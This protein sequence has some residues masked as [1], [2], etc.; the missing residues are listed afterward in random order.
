[1]LKPVNYRLVDA[2]LDLAYN[3]IEHGWDLELGLKDLKARQKSPYTPSVTLPELQAAGVALAFAT[4]FVD[5][6]KYPTPEL[7]HRAAKAQLDRYRRWQDEG[8]VRIVQSRAELQSHLSTWEKDRV[9]GLV[10]LMEGAEPVRRPEEVAHWAKEGVRILGPAWQDT[11]YAGGTGGQKGLTEAGRELLKAMEETGL[12]L[13]L[14]HLS[15]A[16]YFDA[17]EAFSGP[18]LVSHANYRPLAGGPENRHLSEKQLHA[19]KGRGAVVGVVLYNRF[20]DPDWERT[21]P[22]PPLA[23]V[24]RHAEAVARVLGWEAVGIGSDMDGGFGAE[25]LPEGI[26]SHKDWPELAPPFGPHAAGVL[27]ENWIRFLKKNLP[28]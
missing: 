16:A 19:L 24:R 26:L 18:V 1:M 2:H 23:R 6:A 11:R 22:A 9:P 17:L 27:G 21:E 7:A 10:L 28:E 14:S 12:I 25:S 20:L 8:R 13:D 5:P 3:A 15:E 4:L